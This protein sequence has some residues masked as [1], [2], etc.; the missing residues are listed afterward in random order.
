MSRLCANLSELV[1]IVQ[2]VTT[3]T[4]PENLPGPFC[5]AL[6]V[7]PDMTDEQRK[8]LNMCHNK[9]VGHGGVKRTIAKLSLWS[10]LKCVNTHTCSYNNV[11]VAKK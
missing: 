6:R 1:I 10:G 2:P 3:G 7:I 8:A 11:R 9:F 4:E 5:G